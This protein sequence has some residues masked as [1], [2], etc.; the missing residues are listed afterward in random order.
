VISGASLSVRPPADAGLMMMPIAL[1]SSTGAPGA[2]QAVR[3]DEHEM[4]VQNA[5]L[6][7]RCDCKGRFGCQGLSRRHVG[8][9][10][11]EL[12]VVAA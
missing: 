5:H 8:P 6:V 3:D 4:L 11:A 7:A 12:T 1:S 2:K 10:N 9:N